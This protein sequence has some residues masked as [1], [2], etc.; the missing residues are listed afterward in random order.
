METLQTYMLLQKEDGDLEI[1]R[2]DD[3]YDDILQESLENID[4]II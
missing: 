3:F 4:S 1:T 2:I